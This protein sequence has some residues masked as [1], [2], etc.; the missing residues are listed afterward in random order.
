MRSLFFGIC[1]I[2]FWVPSV[3]AEAIPK[4][5]TNPVSGKIDWV[6]DY[7]EGQQQS[8]ASGKPMFVVFR[9]ER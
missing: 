2:A 5:A 6:Y 8:K 4:P 7:A 3:S 1:L 9:C